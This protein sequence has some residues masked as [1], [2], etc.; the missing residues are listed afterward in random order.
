MKMVQAIART[1]AS[2]PGEMRMSDARRV[3]IVGPV[4]WDTV[5]Y[6]DHYPTPGRFTQCR[7]TI[8]RPGG[9]AQEGPPVEAKGVVCDGAHRQFPHNSSR[10]VHSTY[11][12]ALLARIA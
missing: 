9:S 4:A 3:W 2:K 8:E 11:K 7:K 10:L 6:V 5:V 12:N 1:A